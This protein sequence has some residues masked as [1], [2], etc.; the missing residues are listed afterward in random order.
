MATRHIFWHVVVGMRRLRTLLRASAAQSRASMRT[1]YPMSKQP[2]VPSPSAVDANA[3]AKAAPAAVKVAPAADTAA[4]P[5]L[6]PPSKGR[7]VPAHGVRVGE[8]ARVRVSMG[9]T[10]VTLAYMVPPH[11]GGGK[12][13]DPCMVGIGAPGLLWLGVASPPGTALVAHVTDNG[14]AGS[15]VARRMP[16]GSVLVTPYPA[17]YP[18]GCAVTASVV[19][20]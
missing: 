14:A 2:N 13:G 3:A 10:T 19:A 6:A 17:G 20:S 8:L 4:L 1:I 16:G 7:A 12:V 5:P 18:G 11:V 15:V 9:A